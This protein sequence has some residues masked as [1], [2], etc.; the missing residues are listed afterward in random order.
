MPVRKTSIKASGLDLGSSS[1]GEAVS[2]SS[3]GWRFI[4]KR[5]RVESVKKR[6]VR[7]KRSLIRSQFNRTLPTAGEKTIPRGAAEKTIPKKD[8]IFSRSPAAEM[9]AFIAGRLKAE[10]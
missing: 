10:S 6:K 1:F 5:T 8:A 9:Y 2:F 3:G 7:R 4:R